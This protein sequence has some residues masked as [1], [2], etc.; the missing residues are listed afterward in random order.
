MRDLNNEASRR[1]R[2]NRK[3]KFAT[4][5][6][7]MKIETERNADLKMKV[8]ILDEQV[9]RIKDAILKSFVPAANVKFDL[10]AFVKQKSEELNL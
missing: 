6:V 4:L 3:R 7:D 8:R 2:E 9:K 10:D 1:C 5:E